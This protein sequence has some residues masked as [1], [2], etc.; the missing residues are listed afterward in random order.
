MLERVEQLL[1]ELFIGIILGLL[2]KFL[3]ELLISDRD[4]I[5]FSKR[6]EAIR[7]LRSNRG[8]EAT[9]ADKIIIYSKRNRSHLTFIHCDLRCQ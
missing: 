3:F 8:I 2:L 4:S 7:V 1:V 6:M 5:L 9:F